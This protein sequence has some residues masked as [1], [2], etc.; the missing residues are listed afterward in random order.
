[1]KR[2]AK[3]FA[4]V[5]G[6]TSPAIAQTT[7]NGDNLA[8]QS[9]GSAAGSG[10]LLNSDGYVGTYINLTQPAPVTFTLDAS[11]TASGGLSPDMSLSIADSNQSFTVSSSNPTNYTYTTPT[12]AVG[13]YFVRTQLDNQNST[14]T[15]SLDITSLA[16]SGNGVT[17]EN[18][19]TSANALASATTYATNYREGSATLTLTNSNGITFGAGTSVQVKLISNAF[20]FAGAVYGN[21]PYTNDSQWINMGSQGQNLAPTT[22]EQINYQK[23]ILANFNMIVPQNAGK[24]V[25]NEYT[26]GSV[27]MNL[28][29]AMS[30][31]AAQNGLRMRMHNLIWNQEQ[32]TFVNNLFASNG[33]LTTANAA[34][35][36]SDVTSRINYYVSGSNSHALGTPRA[37]SYTEMDVLNE[38]F[39]GQSAQDNYIGSGAL[40]VSGVANIYSQVE[41]AVKAA[42]AGTRLMV[43]E[44]NVLQFSPQSI[45][46]AGVASGSDPYAN[47]YLNGVQSLQ[48]AGAPIG[49]IGMELYTN[50]G[51]NVSAVQMQQA[52]Q[53][54]SVDKDEN[55]NPMPLSLTEFGVATGQ[56]PSAANYDADLT[57]AL[58][59]AYGDPQTDTFGYWG[60]IG[61]P[62]DSGSTIYALYNTNYQLTSAGQTWQN[63]MNQWETN[64][65]LT[66]NSSGQVTFKGTYGLY[67]VIVGGQTYQLDLVKG[68]ANYGLMTP[69]SAATWNGGGANGNW[70]NASNWG[71]TTLVANV[72]L[73]FAG[74][75][76]LA[77]NNDSA[78]NT[79]YSGITFAAGAGPFVIGGNAIN[80][81]GNIV[82]NSSNLQTINT[83]LAMQAGTSF[84]TASDD[85]AMGGGISGAYSLTKTGSHTLTLTGS[86]TYIG[87]TI[88]SAGTLVIGSPGALPANAT[89]SIANSSTMQLAQNIG[90][91]T[92]AS[93]AI[94]GGSRLDITNNAIIVNYGS[95]ADPISSIASLI[96]TG[97]AGGSWNGPGIMSTSAQQNSSSYGIGYADAADP[98]NPGGLGSGQIEI[99]YTL[100]GDANLDG[101]VNGADFSLLATS[102]NQSVTNGWDQGDFNY[103]GAVN[104]ADFVLLANDFNDFASQ[105]SISDLAAVEDF[106]LNNGISLTSV[107]EPAA[108][109][110]IVA[111]G[112]GV[113]RRRRRA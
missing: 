103:D 53:N 94:S 68:T 67:D 78:A 34:T 105:S 112:F 9:S 58:T 98:G 75:N 7:I 89:V 100:L 93:L 102:F 81:A 39:H 35:L 24:W 57:T 108:A 18:S 92:L 88:V 82:N 45:S 51:S 109:A 4:I 13:T 11:G 79:E 49:G 41:S 77:S 48:N 20:N 40:G 17:V 101:K 15:P 2:I 113:F 111:A 21:S 83:N 43:N 38:P 70:S 110:L 91:E 33:T 52:M 32:P 84:N 56:S 87:A 29:D 62:N 97:Y 55:G 72:P 22:S 26:Q 60:G 50:A 5:G 28:V 66:T 76:Q 96:A 44:Y 95:G 27:N 19:N 3:L 104:G 107:P 69:I 16:V 99:I 30:Q 8:L 71:S 12:L 73:V 42:G 1:M 80:L 37:D 106:A 86:N 31:F 10:W 36:N 6:I 54:L 25:N 74:S 59:M 65:T 63:W 90:L 64:D 23:A 85:L 61:G 14:Q 47:W 46:S